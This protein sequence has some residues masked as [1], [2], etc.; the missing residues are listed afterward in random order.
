MAMA[1]QLDTVF[2]WVND[3][4]RSLEWYRMVGLEPGARHGGWQEMKVDGGTRFAL[5]QGPRPAGDSTAVPAFR[6]ADLDAEIVRLVSLGIGASDDEATDTGVAR[7]ITFTDPD[8]NRIQ[9][10]ER[11]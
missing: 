8:G 5:H 1:M 10:L 7:F 3:L 4:D 9:L 2:V 6:V 11:S